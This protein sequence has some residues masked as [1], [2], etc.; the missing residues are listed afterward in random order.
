[1]DTVVVPDRGDGATQEH[2]Y[3][4]AHQD[5]FIKDVQF[6]VSIMLQ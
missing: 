2:A 5:V 4:Q 3:V 1:M 6:Y